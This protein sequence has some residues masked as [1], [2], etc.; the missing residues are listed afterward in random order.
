MNNKGM[1]K[2]QEN[3]ITK[4]KNFLKTIFGKK[5]EKYKRTEIKQNKNDFINDI[6]INSKITDKISNRKRFLKVID[7][8][9]KE[10]KKL[11]IDRLKKLE[12]YYDDIIKN[13]N[14]KIRKLKNS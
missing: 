10:L 4:I 6:K 1:I 2:Y 3:F 11:S 5:E 13:N 7:G 9:E 14:E 8:N 12:E